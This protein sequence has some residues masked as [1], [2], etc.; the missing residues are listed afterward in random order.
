[1]TQLPRT[2]QLEQTDT[3]NPNLKGYYSIGKAARFLN[4]SIDTLRNWEKTGKLTPYR[5][6]TNIRKYKLSDLHKLQASDPKLQ[7][8]AISSKAPYSLYD[9]NISLI[10]N[11]SNELKAPDSPQTSGGFI[12]IPTIKD[13]I[14]PKSRSI[15]IPTTYGLI[16]KTGT[17]L[18]SPYSQ[19]L[20]G[21]FVFC[22][23]SYFAYSYLGNLWDQL[24][25]VQDT[26]PKIKLT[27]SPAPKA[28]SAQPSSTSLSLN[29]M[30]EVGGLIVNGVLEVNSGQIQTKAPILHIGS[31]AQTTIVIGENGTTTFGGGYG[32]T[33]IT[34]YSNGDLSIN[35]KLTVGKTGSFL[36]DVSIT[37]SL[38]VG[39]A[40]IS[41]SSKTLNLFTTN[42]TKINLGG[43]ADIAFVGGYG[44]SGVTF[45]SSGT[46]SANGNLIVDGSSTLS[47]ATNL[48]GTLTASGAI[49]LSGALTASGSSTF[50][51]TTTFEG[52]SDSKGTSKLNPSGSNYVIITTDADSPL[53][54]TGLSS[55]AGLPVCIDTNNNVVLCSGGSSTTSDIQTIYDNS[56]TP[57]L[58]LDSARGALTLRDAATPLGANLFEVQSN[59]GGATY[60]AVTSSGIAVGG[61][62]TGATISAASNTITGLS[63]T[64]FTS[65]DIS[66][67][68]NN[69]GYITATS[70]NTLTNKTIAAA[71]NTITGLTTSNFTSNGNLQWSNDAGYL[72]TVDISSNSN[73][74]ASNGVTLTNDALSLDLSYAPTWTNMHTFTRSGQQLLLKP[75]SAPAANTTLLSVETAGLGS[76]VFTVDYEGDVV[77]SSLTVSTPIAD[78]SVSDSITIGSSGSVSASAI[79]GTL[80]INRGGT[81]VGTFGGTNTILFTTSADTL[82]SITTGNNGALVT[83]GSGVPSISSTLPNAVQDNITRLGIVT[84]GEWRGT[85]V[86][87]QY[88][89]TG[90]NLSSTV[91]GSILY[92]SGTGAMAALGPGSSGQVLISGGPSA[93]PSW[94]AAS[95]LSVGNADTLDSLDSSDFLRATTSTTF[96]GINSRTLTLSSDLSSGTRTADLFTITQANNAS[97]NF[98]TG[99]L[100]TINQA[101]S[102][103][104]GDAIEITQ[105]GSGYAINVT[106]GNVI[107]TGTSYFG[108]TSY[109]INGSGAATVS[110]VNAGS[111]TIQTTGAGNFG[112]SA[113][114]SSG[115]LTIDAS[116][117]LATS[118]TIGTTNNTASTTTAN[119]ALVVA[120]GVG[121]GGALNVGST[122]NGNTFTST[123]LTFGGGATT[124]NTTGNNA[125]LTFNTST[126]ASGNSGNITIQT[127]GTSTSG[128][129]GNVIIDTGAGAAAN[130]SIS[131]GTTN[132]S[133]VS[134]GRSGITTTISGA[135]TQSGGTLNLNASGSNSSNIGNST[136]ALVLTSGGASSWSNTSGNLSLS[137]LTSGNIVMTAAGDISLTGAA[138]SNYT[139]GSTSTTGTITIGQSTAS[140]TINIGNG[141]TGSNTQTVNIAAGTGVKT[142]FIGNNN[143]STA[144]TLTGGDDWSIASNGTASFASLSLGTVLSV[145]NGGTGANS[146]TGLVIGNGTSA[147]TATTVSS[148]IAGVLSDETGS[149]ALVFGTSPNLITPNIGAADGTSLTLSSG[150]AVR[151][152]T[153]NANTLLLQAYDVDGTSYTTFATLTAGNTP[154]MDL[155]SGVTIGAS[156]IYRQGGTDVAV[157]DGGTGVSTFGG[158]NTILYTTAADTLASITTANNGVLITSAGGVPS[159]ASTLPTAVQDNITRTGALVSGSIASGFGTITTANTITGTTINGTTGINTG[160][161]AGTQRIDASGNL[162]NIGTITSGAINSQTI[163]STANFTGTVAIATSLS[164]NSGTALTTTNQT[165]SGSL[166]L[167]TSPTIATPTFTTSITTP[168]IIG[169]STASSTLS[170]QSTSGSGTSDAIKFLVGNNGATEA[171]RIKTDGNV[172]I[173]TTNPANAFAVIST[174]TPQMRIGYDNT[175][176]YFTT[177]V[178]SAGAVTFDTNGASAGFTFSDPVTFSSTLSTTGNITP[179]TDN[180]YDLG[181]TS[182]RWRKVEVGPGSIELSSTTGTSGAGANYTLGTLSFS[183][184]TLKL[185][186]SAVGSGGTGSLQLTTG[187]SVGINVDANGNVGIGTTSPSTALLEVGSTNAF[188]V[189]NGGAI[190]AATG[191]TSSGTIT[192]SG[193]TASRGVFTTTGG[194]LTSSGTSQYLIDSLSDE[195]GTGA[196][197]FGTSPSLTTPNI[198]AATGASLTLSTGGAVRTSTSDTNTLLLQAY[199]VDGTT[200]TTFATLTAGNTPTMDLA[201]SVTIG[202]GNY[203]YRSGGTDVPVADGGTGT[204]TL[205]GIIKGNGTSAFTAITTSAGISGELSDETGSGA[206]VFAT[207]PSLTT[208]NIGAATGSSLNLGS[209]AI[210][211][212]AINS[213]TISSTANFTG[214]VAI[215]TSLSINSGTAL[216]TTNQSGTGSLVMTNSPTLVTPTLGAAS[217][218]SLTLSSGGGVQT[219]TS[220][221]NTLLLRAYDVDGTSYTTFATLT[222]GNTPT[223]DLA[224]GVT[225]GSSYIYRQGGTDVSVSDGGTGLSTFG[226]TN[227]ILYTTAADTLASI[228][229]ANNGV[230]IT[231]AGGVPSISSTLPTAV[232]DN[233][234]RSGALA[235]GSIASGFGTIATSNTITGTTINGT[236][237]INT[238]ASAG[239]QRIDA[240][241][242]LVN[243]GTITS[244]AQTIT[245]TSANALAVGANGTTNPVLQID[246]NTGSVAT[247]IKI[248]GAAAAGGVNVAAI[249]S[250]TD[251]NL[252]LNAKGTGTITL[253]NTSTGNITLTRATTAT[254]GLTSTTTLIASNGFTMSTGALSLTST[255]GAISSTG[256]TGLTQTLSSGTAAITAPT[257]NLNTTG[258]GNTT[259]GNSAGGTITIGASTGSDLALNDAQWSITGAG[260]ASFASLSLGSGSVSGGAGSFTTLTSSGA[261]TIA[262][263]ASLTN[264]FGT[265]SSATNTI[266]NSTGTNAI[267]GATT[268]LG[269][270][271][272]NSTGTSATTIGN[273]TGALVLA[274]GG[275]SSW[276]N[277][278]GNLTIQT[279]TSG[280]LALDSA[281]A[282]NIGNTNATSLSLG[283]TG[284]T[285]TNN[286]SL[287]ST[288]TLTA[289][290][291]FTLTTGALGLTATSGSI[292]ATGLTGTTITNSSGNIALTASTGAINLT[293]G[294]ASTLSTVA[295]TAS[296]FRIT[297]GTTAYHGIDTRTGTSGVAANSFTASA[298]TIAS[299]AS[300]YFNTASF[301]PAT[302][303]FSGSTQITSTGTS[304]NNALL[305]NQP[306]INRTAAASNL[307]I[308][309]ASNLFI[310]GPT[311][312]THATGGQTETITTSAA[313]RIGA[314]ASLAGTNGAVTN[315]YGLYVDAPTGATGNYAAVFASGNVGIGST[316]PGTTLDVT[317]TGR[318]SST[319]TA[320]TFSS[321]GVTISGGTINGTTIGASS[322]STGAF[323]TL[324]STGATTLGNNSSTVAIDTSSWDISSAGAV[325]GVTTLASTYLTTT[326]N[327]VNFTGASTVLQLAGTQFMDASRNLSNIGT[328]ASGAHT[329]TSTSANALAV[330]ANGTTNPVLQIDANTGSVATGIK[331][332]GAAAAGGV[333]IAAISS[334][335]DENLTLNA[336]GTGTITLGNTSTGNI[337]LTRATTASAG[338]T[339]TTTLVASNGFTMSTG[340]LSLTSTSGSISSTGLTGLTQTLSSGTAAITAPT[341]NLNTTGTG[342]T[343]IGNSTGALTLVSGGTS[344]WANTSGNLTLSTVTSG[345]LALTSAGA[346]NLTAAAASTLS[347]VANTASAFR[348]TDGT[349]AYHGIDTRTGTSGVAANSF[350]ASAPTI[351]SGA[352]TFF[353]TAAFSPA[354]VNFSGSTQITSTGTSANNALLFNQP[355][356]NRTAAASNLT[357]DQASN[358][359]I[360]GP[361]IATHATGGQT[362]TIT[363][364]AALRIGAGAS[365][366][367]TNGA[368]TNGYGLYVDAPTGATNNVAAYFNGNV[369]IGST[370]PGTTLD[371]TGTG[372]FSSTLTANTFSSSGVTI[373]GGTIN[374]TTIGASSPSTGAFTTLSSTGVTALG[375]NSATVAIDS[376]DWDISATGVLTGISGITTDGGYTQSGTTANTF[377]GA[378]SLSYTGG[379]ILSIANSAGNVELQGTSENMFNLYTE[380]SLTFR[381]DSDNDSTDSYSFFN[382][383]NSEIANL[384]ESGDLQLDGKLNVDSASASYIIG[385]VGIGTTNATSNLTILSSATTGTAASLTASSISTGNGL[386]IVG[387]TATGITGTANG[388]L[389]VTG[390]VGSAGTAGQLVYLAPDFSAGATTTGYG[391]R[392]VGTD[393]TAIANDNYGISNELTFTGNAQKTG[394]GIY[395]YLSDTSTKGAFLTGAYS[396]VNSTGIMADSNDF[397]VLEAFSAYTANSGATTA[398]D[399]DLYGVKINIV[400]TNTAVASTSINNAYGA[401]INVTNTF[402]N[403]TGI[404]NTYGIRI[405]SVNASTNGTST[406]Y[407]LFIGD[408]TNSPADTNYAIYSGGGNSYFAGNI[409]IGTTNPSS[410]NLQVTGHIGATTND[411]YD[412]GSDSL[413]WRDL[414]LGPDTLH[415]GTSTSD[416]GYISY[417]T[418]TNVLNM[419]STGNIALQPTSGNIGIGTTDPAV[420]KFIVHDSSTST[421]FSSDYNQFPINLRNTNTTV[422]NFGGIGFF[423]GTNSSLSAAIS[424]QFTNHGSPT[425]NLVFG[426]NNAGSFGEKM[427]IT[428][429]GN[430]GIGTTNP[431]RVLHVR[432]ST[433]N[434]NSL[435][436]SSEFDLASTGTAAAGLGNLMQFGLQNASGTMVAAADLGPIWTTATNGAEQ[437]ALIFRTIN[438]TLGERMRID[439]V[440]NV[441]IGTTVPNGLLQL[442][443]GTTTANTTITSGA[444]GYGLYN[445][446]TI[447]WT[448][449]N[450]TNAFGDYTSFRVA[451]GTG[452]TLTN[453]YGEYIDT[454]LKV[455]AGNGTGT[456]TNAYGLY[457]NTPTA[458]TNNYGAQINGPVGF[459]TP[460]SL[461]LITAS[462]SFTGSTHAEGIRLSS[463]LTPTTGNQVRGVHIVPTLGSSTEN[464]AVAD[465]LLVDTMTKGNSGTITTL[466]GARILNQSA[467]ATTSYGLY[468]E[469]PTGGATN[470]GGYFGG[471]VGIGNTDPDHL[472]H[473]YST[474]QS[475]EFLEI[476][477]TAADS[478]PHLKL[479]N[480]AQSWLVQTVGARGDNFEISRESTTGM[481]SIN[482]SGN[483][484]IGTSSPTVGPIVGK[485]LSIYNSSERGSIE[486]VNASTGT[487]GVGGSITFNN[488]STRLAQIDG[489]AD[490]ATNNGMMLLYTTSGGTVNEQVRISS[491]GNVGFGTTTTSS[492]KVNV[493]GSL[494]ATSVYSGGVLL[495]PGTGSN[496]TVTG[497]DVYRA[498]G[499]V[500]IGSATPGAKLHLANTSQ[501]R[502]Y[503]TSTSNSIQ[504][505]KDATPTKAVNIGMDVPGVGALTDDMVFSTFTGS[506][507]AE[508]MR[509]T[510]AGNV[511]IGTSS[512]TDDGTGAGGA[513]GLPLLHIK[514]TTSAKHPKVL[515]DGP[516]DGG[517]WLQ[518][519]EAGVSQMD[520]GHSN[521]ANASAWVNRI[522][523]EPI[524]FY[525]NNGS[526]TAVRMRLDGNGNLG[527]GTTNPTN[528]FQIEGTTTANMLIKTTS[529]SADT[530]LKF[531][532]GRTGAEDWW[533]LGSSGSSN[534]EDNFRIYNSTDSLDRFVI[535]GGGNVG[536]GTNTPTDR[537]EVAGPIT[538]TASMVAAKASSVSLSYETGTPYARLISFG[539]NASTNGTLRLISSRSDGTNQLA[540]LTGDV[541]GNV[542]INTTTATQKLEVN[543]SVKITTGSGGGFVFAD[544]T[545]QTT[546]AATGASATGVSTTAD[547]IINSSTTNTVQLQTA[548]TA[549]LYVANGGN[550]GIGTNTPGFLLQVQNNQNATTTGAIYNLT[551]G[552]GASARQ[553]VRSDAA[554]LSLSSQAS[555]YTTSGVLVQ[556]ASTI[557]TDGTG[558]LHL[559]ATDATGIIGF[560]TGGS[561]EKM[562]ISSGGN[563]GIGTTTTGTLGASGGPGKIINI[564]NSSTT[565]DAGIS[566]ANNTTT[567]GISVGEIQF[568]TYGT[569]DTNKQSALIVSS[570]YASAATNITGGLEFYTTN[571]GTTT[572][573][574]RINH[575]G[576]V[577]IGTTN[578]SHLLDLIQSNTGGTKMRIQNP[579]AGTGNY[580]QLN[581]ASDTVTVAL[582]S[583]ASTWTTSG[584]NLQSG[585]ALSANGSGGLSVAATHASGA[586]RFY[587]GG[588]TENMRVDTTGNVGIGSTAPAAKLD[589]TGTFAVSGNATFST[590]N[591]ANGVIYANASGTLLNTGAGTT[592]QCLVATTG[593]NPTWGSC[594]GS[595]TMSTSWSNITNPGASLSLAMGSN[596]TT[597]TYNAVTSTTNLFN[598]TDTTSNTGTG[599]LLN[600]TTAS[601]STLNPLHI[602]AAG[603]EA[604]MVTASGNIGIG[605]TTPNTL[606]QA[607]NSTGGDM[608]RLTSASSGDTTLVLAP[609]AGTAN[610]ARITGTAVS[611]QTEL[612]FLTGGSARMRIDGSGNVGIGTT[613]PTAQLEVFGTAAIIKSRYST[614]QT[615]LDLVQGS[616]GE[617]Y[618][619]NRDAQPLYFGTNN[620]T[621]MA[622]LSNGNVG[623]GTTNPGQ[624]LDVNGI[625]N[626]RSYV[627]MGGSGVANANYTLFA[628][629]SFTGN[630]GNSPAA[631]RLDG[632]ITGAVND[633]IMGIFLNNTFVEAASGTHAVIT[634]LHL[635]APTI[636]NAGGATAVAATAYISGAPTGVTGTT[637]NFA[638]YSNSGANYFGG[639]VGIGTTGP[640]SILHVRAGTDKNFRITSHESDSDGVGIQ[641]YNDANNA[642][643][644]LSF[645]AS[646]YN[647]SNGNVGI[648]TTAP[649]TL[650]HLATSINETAALT[651]STS[652]ILK[653]SNTHNTTGDYSL[654]NFSFPANDINALIG[655]KLANSGDGSAHLVFGTRTSSTLAERMRITDTGNV[656]IGTTGPIFALHSYGGAAFN[657]GTNLNVR[658]TAQ[659]STTSVQAVNDAANAFVNMR[660]DGLQLYLN[661]QSGGNVGIGTTNPANGHTVA[662]SVTADTRATIFEIINSASGAQS[663][664]FF[665]VSSTCGNAANTAMTICRDAGTSRSINA[666]G[667][668][669][670]SG[671]DY[672]EYFYQETPGSLQK[673]DLVCLSAN[674]K[675]TRCTDAS[676][677]IGVVSTNP[678]YVGNDLFDPKNPDNT[679]LV[680]I[681]GQIPTL[682]STENGSIQR[683]DYLT[684]SSTP[685]VAMKAT[686]P[687]PIVGKAIDDY[688]GNGTGRI[689]LFVNVSYADPSNVLANLTFDTDGSLIVPSLKAG[690]ITISKDL[691]ISGTENNGT[692]TIED[693]LADNSTAITDIGAKLTLASE[694]ILGVKTAIEELES[695]VASLETQTATPSATP[696]VASDSQTAPQNDALEASQSAAIAA[697]TESISL[698]RDSIASL[699]NDIEMKLTSPEVMIA[700]GSATLAEIN[701][702]ETTS[703]KTLNAED[704][705]ISGSLTAFGDTFLGTTTIAG[706]LSVDGTFSITEGSKINAL[707]VLY[708]QTTPL[709]EAVDFFNGL[710]TFDKTGTINAK[711]VKAA[712]ITTEDLKLKSG[713]SAGTGTMLIGQ[714]SVEIPSS[715]VHSYSKIMLTITNDA[716]E[717]LRVTAKVEGDHFVV[718]TRRPVITQVDFDWVIINTEP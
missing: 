559:A 312:A 352:S 203:I 626:F 675:A 329:I 641:S 683:G 218:T 323:T 584:V 531:D 494:N 175:T 651:T 55:A 393:S 337:T 381:I 208:P 59:N 195:T 107:F 75:S 666:G 521:S 594:S 207:S 185:A 291:G 303:N 635:T 376:S 342:N 139:V 118:G 111:G 121:I 199:D 148:G 516:T 637:G 624:L 33:G 7:Q 324:S 339:S 670:A 260:A 292:N 466:Y 306:T 133:A 443:T 19:S 413:R 636:T 632:A 289:T 212:G 134:I 283:R 193:L 250:G 688:S 25:P 344:S 685:G 648:G 482:T 694:E 35:G 155:A 310:N 229:T 21:L 716:E 11:L 77:A 428:A 504:F 273:S 703:T 451:P 268:I 30:V 591:T 93:N 631:L 71:S 205:T 331:I 615:G 436:V 691:A 346:I 577:G 481:F 619:Y 526:S 160:A 318:F 477:S 465:G 20:M 90:Q 230:L 252:T 258:T 485:V 460:N 491:T 454:L 473:L 9:P 41:A 272:I 351:A 156:Y 383:A 279:A 115:Q 164:I 341:L 240:S 469:A 32:N 600:V 304:A 363:T 595:S 541:S 265:G 334:G 132:A 244:G 263:G 277:T 255:S 225:I 553:L 378:V 709:A 1:M 202:G 711:V 356:I 542:G 168:L 696:V 369:G 509:I 593:S 211:S 639:N 421:T 65:A 338:L 326:T 174:S 108:S 201:S 343:T 374:G 179:S 256:L 550:I 359:F 64:N 582:N 368:V 660:V 51:G 552:T 529:T 27:G 95:A 153:S 379:S 488:G 58:I 474:T 80:A 633:T 574:M 184:T 362:E 254:N 45:T 599:Y 332:T 391:L 434:T 570:L 223:M 135:L 569:A 319:L 23:L 419:Q 46:I 276:T 264:T 705:A 262:T 367:G 215:T 617:G 398:G 573:K 266:G 169:G 99:N 333:N 301:T 232:Q 647:F 665:G 286:G 37:G 687:G 597:L 464:I 29:E 686:R 209:G 13:E 407:G 517:A 102:G 274:S 411:T 650:T 576:N 514:S 18:N 43:D 679:V 554:T 129:S 67:W 387:P 463:A 358:L 456:V 528:V 287:T 138:S 8:K 392:I 347:T 520:I 91:Q 70:T 695:R 700:T 73:L 708:F 63:T 94:S 128:T 285:T 14:R 144:L 38:S 83:N 702:T 269:T 125:G 302:V 189:T 233:I 680:G 442:G 96:T 370:Q 98:T 10:E 410:F 560:Y 216:T 714:S 563:I 365:L 147:M 355:T 706:D 280:T 105:A 360:N 669:N 275:T 423:S 601:G 426:T 592:G 52:L 444:S 658:M 540:W 322:P 231:S 49:N 568:G 253:G 257:L 388:M 166:V 281:G 506:A 181:T 165:G 87:T 493:N 564:Y 437:S 440:G 152:S 548:G 408:M 308:D 284:V 640:N 492:Y 5:T 210:T 100:V 532:S 476:Q 678:G 66:Q 468:V 213:Q 704:V 583:L 88:G 92:F 295:N 578:P 28:V 609:A 159:I 630:G 539:A 44:S 161:S 192:F 448:T 505:Y 238:G 278:S 191:I 16:H 76:S 698:V 403:D 34:A 173:G 498:A 296:A 183:S 120:G 406:K 235:S 336:K 455:D 402:A 354:T 137:T 315:G 299:G 501:Q 54:V 664:A 589:V 162:V 596:S 60:F 544:G 97:N 385:N 478:N 538:S 453:A 239:T 674:G 293:A 657:Q 645:Q 15:T 187:S 610:A 261:S 627:G 124:I 607:V 104:T 3:K 471:N 327:V 142:V 117:N 655:A 604:L 432:A 693:V 113:I 236:T 259:I 535:D 399:T 581:V 395:N 562:R 525:T 618:L 194:Q 110:S 242:N 452:R 373:S 649:F 622:I 718:S 85:V 689:N 644:S 585:S 515:I 145:A 602:S 282:L 662:R 449:A 575:T 154:T 227:T 606:I 555:T 47:G 533:I 503:V 366:A 62:I 513:N 68:T 198:G 673:G 489:A 684:L 149:G 567:S 158:T 467:T 401:N 715:L 710:I 234:T 217:A 78:S 103:S 663:A 598:L 667:T 447:T 699:Q 629:R 697:N 603:T 608:L 357:I 140:N 510:N 390:D 424:A 546:A 611:T 297:D 204:S 682:V 652:P 590:L 24:T 435:S 483:V 178:S 311:I 638:L 487:S 690:K 558:G 557:Q 353:N 226:G 350:T 109:S 661:A 433:A 536:I 625:S 586:V 502:F 677:M 659:S 445:S 580:G 317:G 130:G 241:G 84:S 380:G 267:N 146:L 425:A 518:L 180:T 417:T 415:I 438:T 462:S 72:T 206:L 79:T 439:A 522:S 372:R 707:P 50:S 228:T 328:I 364:S 409:G 221:G 495:T 389:K 549:R 545:T 150:G 551:A 320:N 499:N 190:S 53:K 123:A 81:G 642:F 17:I 377:T 430:V 307:T 524:D 614:S 220:N 654:I 349:T 116:G 171:M 57:E 321:S 472:L 384:N 309:Q 508:R 561:T 330:G 31:G 56:S 527:I 6:S 616:S 127:G 245:S 197:V 361:T 681:V 345:T 298:P 396:S 237:G 288:Q 571:A 692:L 122:I 219:S 172:G 136:G 479:T 222:A 131:I 157:T 290:N 497:S 480:D 294:A 335:T 200:Y 712:S 414:Y 386:S 459:G 457:V 572:E 348:I 405:T 621:K 114:G 656:G 186:T 422:N 668:I 314:G 61:S 416:E 701:V 512:P 556:S 713:K 500:G 382:G 394:T 69:S 224:S 397:K 141:A 530:A 82:S 646:K 112:T 40:D 167:S 496:W 143:T 605:T 371:V 676:K 420:G 653:I 74:S 484:G 547:A 305:F 119:G 587:A 313:L 196:L 566:L 86:G 511:G 170:L 247:G 613:A 458:G 22:T 12:E 249:S 375:N 623:I 672:A 490:G 101:D 446:P 325:T 634:Q 470:V 588:S 400:G 486:L 42:T 243:I 248:T 163:S 106:S 717:I 620:S 26:E 48:S 246:A 671:A 427:R 39:G 176:N 475:S 182:L 340:A 628:S 431:T 537:F 418:A 404:S 543:G 461:A 89:G 565:V 643:K 519:M 214:T 271:L 251:E 534:E 2:S 441:G 177:A 316:T 300:T 450:A 612:S 36:S 523:G 579:T 4:V 126:G 270:T 151:T 188:K 429:A 507:W 412:L